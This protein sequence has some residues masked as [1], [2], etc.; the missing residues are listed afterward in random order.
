M[1]LLSDKEALY[2][3][4]RKETE[5]LHKEIMSEKIAMLKPMVHKAYYCKDFNTYFFVTH[6]AENKTAPFGLSINRSEIM[7]DWMVNPERWE[8]IPIEVF[9]DAMDRFVEERKEKIQALK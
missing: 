9:L 5:R 4:Y 7:D 2:E 1:T 3:K 8:E 6:I